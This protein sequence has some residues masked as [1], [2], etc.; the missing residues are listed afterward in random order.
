MK[1]TA[2]P[3]GK[4]ALHLAIESN[5]P[6]VVKFLFMHGADIRSVDSEGNNCLHYAA[7]AST[8]M[9]DVSIFIH[10]ISCNLLDLDCLGT[11]RR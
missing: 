2:Q 10:V 6:E 3:E 7:L 11:T 5:Q 9:I 8:Q 4:Y 1:T